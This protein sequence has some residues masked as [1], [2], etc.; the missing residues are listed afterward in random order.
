VIGDV[1]LFP[2]T[3]L[4]GDGEEQQE[5]FAHDTWLRREILAGIDAVNAGEVVSAEEVKAEAAAWRAEIQRKS[6]GSTSTP[7]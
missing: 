7:S 5:D 6:D 2:V 4:H 3:C 1:P